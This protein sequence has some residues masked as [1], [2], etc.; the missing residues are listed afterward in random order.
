MKKLVEKFGSFQFDILELP[1]RGI[2]YNIGRSFVYVKYLTAKEEN[3]LSTPGLSETNQ[4]LDIVIE[5]VLLE[6]I[7]VD[8]LISVDRKAII[9]FLRSTS[10]GDNFELE[11]VCSNCATKTNQN[12]GFSMLEMSDVEIN[13]NTIFSVKLKLKEGEDFYDIRFKPLTY[14][15]EKEIKLRGE[16]RIITNTVI[17]Q[18]YE[19]EHVYKV[20]NLEDNSFMKVV[21][22]EKEQIKKFISS[23]PLKKFQ[24]LRQNMEKKLPNI[25]EELSCECPNC[26]QNNKFPFQV[27]DSLL[28]LEPRYRTNFEEEIFLI[29]YYGKGGFDKESLYNTSIMSRRKTLERINN[30]I[31]KKNKAEEEAVRKSKNKR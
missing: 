15:Q 19:I 7:K 23:L 14:G 3:I 21:Y 11:V 12:F 20:D 29:Q 5:S 25:V 13:E 22:S 18:I 8:E 4:A 17:S 9:L 27:D 10:F 24:E 1:S 28:K 31:E 2:F 16:N 30:E 6:D 26:G